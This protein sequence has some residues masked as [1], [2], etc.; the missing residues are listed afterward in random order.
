[1]KAKIIRKNVVAESSSFDNNTQLSE[2]NTKEKAVAALLGLE[3]TN[4]QKFIKQRK[5]KKYDK[6]FDSYCLFLNEHFK[7]MSGAG[8]WFHGHQ[9][10]NLYNQLASIYVTETG[11]CN[12]AQAAYND[13]FIPSKDVSEYLEKSGIKLKYEQ[14]SWIYKHYLEC[15]KLTSCS[16]KKAV[17]LINFERF[18]EEKHAYIPLLNTQRIGFTEA[19]GNI[20]E[21]LYIEVEN[22]ELFG[23]DKFAIE[24]ISQIN[25][26]KIT[27]YDE[28]D[29]NPTPHKSLAERQFATKDIVKWIIERTGVEPLPIVREVLL[30]EVSCEQKELE[31]PKGRKP[32]YKANHIASKLVSLQQIPAS[33]TKELQVE[34]KAD[35]KTIRKAIAIA[36]KNKRPS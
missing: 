20:E 11:F 3:P 17:E 25:G 18:T 9:V 6:F 10:E 35:A 31:S 16:L 27:I 32:A 5:A 36:K 23:R 33:A 14:D 22:I 13:S 19:L 2:I 26:R 21:A 29:N 24:L 34:H 28:P 4:L 30:D 12:F 8:T 1:M 15:S 7:A